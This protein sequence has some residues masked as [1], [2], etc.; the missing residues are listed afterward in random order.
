M[1]KDLKQLLIAAKVILL[2]LWPV[3][4]YAATIAFGEQMAQIPLLSMLMTVILSTL[5]GAT[6]LLHAMKQEYEK[7]DDINR[8]WLFVTSRMLSSNAAG[9]LMFFGAES[10]DGIATSH[11]AAAIML[12]A[13]G[14]TW[15][16]ER[17]LQF[18][19]NKYAPEPQK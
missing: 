12:A 16:I 3:S 9:L 10:W 17:A 1:N 13:F 8:L 11:K 7:T 4:A 2:V 14:G 6:A 19:S 5:M 18:F 15:T